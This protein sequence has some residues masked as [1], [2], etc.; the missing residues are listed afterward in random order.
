MDIDSK[1]IAAAGNVTIG[2]QINNFASEQKTLP[3][4]LPTVRDFIGR[5]EDLDALR[6]NYKNE[7]RVF[8][9]HGVGGVGKTALALEFAHE[10]KGEYAAHIFVDMQ[11]LNRPV[12]AAEAAMYEVV[13][14]FDPNIP[15]NL[16]PNELQG[17]YT[18]FLTKHK[19]LLVLDNAYDEQQI[20]PLNVV[21]DSCLLVT[22]RRR[23]DLAGGELYEVER[24]SETDAKDLLISICPRIGE[25]ADDLAERCGRLPLALRATASALKKNRLIPV[26]KYIA[27]LQ[28]RKTRLLL[29][30]PTRKNLTVEAA[31]DLSYEMLDA[32]L[33]L[34]WRRLAVFP[35]DFAADGAAAIWEIDDATDTLNDLDGYSLLEVNEET[36]RLS[37]HDLAR[38]YT[39]EKLTEEE[40][41]ALQR[42]HSKHYAVFLESIQIKR[43]SDYQNALDLLDMEWDN[44]TAGQKLSVELAETDNEFTQICLDYSD[45]AN[46]FIFMRLNP[47]DYIE[48]QSA[49]LIAAQKLRN[50][51]AESNRLG[52]LGLAYLNLGEYRKAF[53]YHEQYLQIS[54]EIGDRYGEGKSLG[55]LGNTYHDL[56]EYR[57]AIEYYEQSLQVSREIGDRLGEGTSLGNLGNTYHSLG[58]YRKAIEYHEKSL[59]IKCEIGNRYGE[60]KS[61][62]NLGV[63]YLNLG[64]Y[65]KAIDY[66]EQSL[67]I[68]RD[69]G[70]GIGEGK[71]LRNLG[72]VYLNLGEMEKACRLLSESLTILKAIESPDADVVWQLLAEYCQN[73]D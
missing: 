1:N 65:R 45:Y 52:S 14:Q 12:L 43:A 38:D 34:R 15:A 66:L 49:G 5:G 11:G 57:K 50:R 27:D 46:E 44:I 70:Y 20:E 19:T 32:D 17:L 29:A 41:T 22:S 21:E 47:R 69:I 42:L 3:S 9:L 53:E 72:I 33:Q 68:S 62:G 61:L 36:G 13:K 63:A 16:S 8:L 18:Q 56:G 40:F 71:S 31:F 2:T 24:M 54:G 37:L 6:K 25:R 60:G 64:E 59:Q 26:E 48:W 10:I 55:N 28:D 7:K 67:Q 58:E 30:D 23:F 73:G 4:N 51:Q 35:V 39:T